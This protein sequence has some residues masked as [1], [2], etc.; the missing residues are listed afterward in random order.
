M[1][2]YYLQWQMEQ[3]L[4]PL[5]KDDGEG[6]ER[7]WTFRGVI[8]CLAQITRNKVTVNGAEFYQNSTPTEE[9]EQILSLLEVKM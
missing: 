6:K 9:Q 8:D 3:R 1:L 2:A 5:F 4:S 7:R